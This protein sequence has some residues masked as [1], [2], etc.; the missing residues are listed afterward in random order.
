[1]LPGLTGLAVAIGDSGPTAIS[2]VDSVSAGGASSP[3][4]FSGVNFGQDYVGRLLVACIVLR[5]NAASAVDQTAVTI[6]GV[7]ATGSDAGSFAGGGPACGCGLWYASPGG[8]SGDVVVTWTGQA[9]SACGLIL[10]S[11]PLVSLPAFDTDGALGVLT[12]A[13]GSLDIPAGGTLIVAVAHANTND[14]SMTNVTKRTE[15][16]IASASIVVGYDQQ[17]SSDTGRSVSA[18]W[19]GPV[20][21]GLQAGSFN[22]T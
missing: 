4:T 3:K 17:M 19:S 13:T 8:A 9:A 18:S 22:P 5:G 7:S 2:V 21:A 14:A 20:P 11:V 6:G 16:D 12:S 15:L 10:L 1:M